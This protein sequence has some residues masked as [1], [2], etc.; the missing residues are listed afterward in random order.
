MLLSKV[1]GQVLSG[2]YA[3][4]F[5]VQGHRQNVTGLMQPYLTAWHRSG[6]KCKG[7]SRY[8][9]CTWHQGGM[10]MALPQSLP[11][12]AAC[13]HAYY[14]L[15]QTYGGGVHMFYAGSVNMTASNFSGN[16]AVNG[17]NTSGEQ[18]VKQLRA[19]VPKCGV[20]PCC[21]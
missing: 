8:P 17:A 12:P 15:M 9:S 13:S 5:L 3:T 11:Y 21:T 14:L 1:K 7:S 6:L 18:P 2:R 19:A 16:Q 10:V 4:I 20:I